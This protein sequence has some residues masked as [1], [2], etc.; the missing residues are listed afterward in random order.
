MEYNSNDRVQRNTYISELMRLLDRAPMVSEE[1]AVEFIARVQNAPSL[2]PVYR[3]V[4]MADAYNHIWREHMKYVEDGE[5]KEIVMV[6]R[7]KASANS[8]IAKDFPYAFWLYLACG[9]FET[10]C[11]CAEYPFCAAFIKPG[12]D[13]SE[14]IAQVAVYDCA[15]NTAPLSL[16]TS[17]MRYTKDFGRQW[18]QP[19]GESPETL[20][21]SHWRALILLHA[22]D[23][24]FRSKDFLQFQG[25]GF[26][27]FFAAE[28]YSKPPC[29]VARQK[30]PQAAWKR[31]L[32]TGW[33]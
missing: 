19:C 20:M 24:F 31:V 3:S 1:Q 32:E 14:S 15:G 18:L 13:E 28:N 25:L 22:D 30:S 7:D 16:A 17:V 26:S 27:L 5:T 8:A 6:S 11:E 23:A 29:L 4:H 10:P 9:R 2:K 12:Q 33:N 21:K